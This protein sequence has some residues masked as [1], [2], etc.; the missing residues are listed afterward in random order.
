MGGIAREGPMRY[1]VLLVCAG[2]TLSA[3]TAPH[4]PGLDEPMRG[5]VRVIDP[6]ARPPC[7]LWE[8]VE[9]LARQAQVRIG[10]EQDPG[11][12][13]GG[14]PR[15]PYD[16][17]AVTLDGLTPRAAFDRLLSH[18]SDYR[19]AIIDGVAVFRPTTAWAAG[20]P[21]DHA[22]APFSAADH[23]H[24]VLHTLLQSARPSL[25]QEHVD[26]LLSS[27]A[28][29]LDDPQ[30]VA[31]I[32]APVSVSFA[33]GRLL[34][35]L[36]AVTRPFAGIWQAAYTPGG[37]RQHLWLHLMTLDYDGG[38]VTAIS[39]PVDVVATQR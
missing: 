24:H 8:S 21:L 30:A 12:R 13:P 14:R 18:R 6:A 1:A 29:R 4:L 16:R 7:E 20:S 27:Y 33:G 38:S 11:C 34:H 9:Q 35:A 17:Q 37:G 39:A 25:F 15:E 3:Q 36:N 26:A 2:I 10:F 5:T 28:K 23:P 22:V 32:D 19:W 31:P